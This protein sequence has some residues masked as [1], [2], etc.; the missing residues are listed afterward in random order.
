MQTLERA[1]HV[2]PG[3]HV[4]WF[5]MSIAK[6]KAARKTLEESHTT[7]QQLQKAKGYLTHAESTLERLKAIAVTG[8]HGPRALLSGVGAGRGGLEDEDAI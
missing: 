4:V 8:A 5:N 6:Y 1:A 7:L 3:E 2:A